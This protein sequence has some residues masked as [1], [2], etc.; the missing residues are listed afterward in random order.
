MKNRTSFQVSYTSP[1]IQSDGKRDVCVFHKLLNGGA[2]TVLSRMTGFG[3]R[4]VET[5]YRSPCGQFWL[6]SGDIDIR[7]HLDQFE[8]EEDMIDFVMRNAN[9]CRGGHYENHYPKQSYQ[10]FP[11]G[12]QNG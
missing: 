6:A 2:I 12:E 11:K 1:D 9:N 10:V 4:D 3:W 5:G 8:T 7:E